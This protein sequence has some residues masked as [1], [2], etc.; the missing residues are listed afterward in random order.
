MC[1]WV[2]IVGFPTK[3]GLFYL[4]RHH[5]SEGRESMQQRARRLRWNQKVG[6]DIWPRERHALY[7]LANVKCRLWI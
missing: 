7:L 2:N 1:G 5:N 6:R 4:F 3:S